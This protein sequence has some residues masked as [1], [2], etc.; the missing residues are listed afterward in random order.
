MDSTETVQITHFVRGTLGCRCPDDVF[1]SITVDSREPIGGSPPFTRLVIGDRLL[2]F[3]AKPGPGDTLATWIPGLALLGQAEREAA[4]YN[5]FRLVV[6]AAHVDEQSDTARRVFAETIGRD[7][8]AHLH[9][10]APEDLPA[11]A[12]R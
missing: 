11:L 4:G 9:I 6:P 5:R 1:R 8:R 2:I 12:E 10:V 3:L 7:D